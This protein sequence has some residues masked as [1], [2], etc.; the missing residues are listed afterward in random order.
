MQ[1]VLS[2]RP[3]PT[4]CRTWISRSQTPLFK[5]RGDEGT[6]LLFWPSDLM[7]SQVTPAKTV[8]WLASLALGLA[9]FAHCPK[10]ALSEDSSGRNQ[11][12]ALREDFTA[13]TMGRR[14]HAP[15]QTLS[16]C[17]E[18]PLQLATQQANDQEA[19]RSQG[20]DITWSEHLRQGS[21]SS[22]TLLGVPLPQAAGPTESFDIT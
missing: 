10:R 19:E 9:E 13:V 18:L 11:L 8:G 14:K 5:A 2:S 20:E 22:K 21:I 3:R 16:L 17:S 1:K 12:I 6:L 15:A 7:P 4:P